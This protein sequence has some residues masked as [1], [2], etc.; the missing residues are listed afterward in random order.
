LARSTSLPAWFRSNVVFMTDF[1]II[2]RARKQIDEMLQS[3]V[4]P[5]IIRIT[6]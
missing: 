1:S 5:V 4:A 3:A 6:F 2:L